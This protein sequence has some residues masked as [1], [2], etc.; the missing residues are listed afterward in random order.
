MEQLPLISITQTWFWTFLNSALFK[1]T[2]QSNAQQLRYRLDGKDIFESGI[3]Q[4]HQR[5]KRSTRSPCLW[6]IYSSSQN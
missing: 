1:Y 2:Q 4:I 6:Y 3:D 5:A